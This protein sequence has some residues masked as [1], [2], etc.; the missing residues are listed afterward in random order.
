HTWRVT[1]NQSGMYFWQDYVDGMEPYFSVPAV[2]IEDVEEPVRV[3]P[4]N[5]PGYTVFPI[6]NLAVGGSGGGD[7]RQGSYPAD[8]LIDWVRVF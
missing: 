5:D 8:M 2:G 1:W 3:W 7:A 4:F 6:L